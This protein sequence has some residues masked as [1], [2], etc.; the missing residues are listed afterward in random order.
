[1]GRGEKDGISVEL[2]GGW[3]LKIVVEDAGARRGRE[4]NSE[5]VVDVGD[6]ARETAREAEDAGEERRAERVDEALRGD[7][8]PLDVVEVGVGVEIAGAEVGLDEETTLGGIDVL[9]GM[10][11]VVVVQADG[12]VGGA[13][14]V[15]IER[16]GK[17]AVEI[18]LDET[19]AVVLGREVV[20]AREAVPLVAD[21]HVDFVIVL[22]V[23]VLSR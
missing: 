9:V 22:A 6:V 18:G 23:H 15:A 8:A 17:G 10:G 20:G 21:A 11:D 1:M 3:W 16:H 4:A 12:S 13:A 2:G 14:L 7:V 19:E 5:D